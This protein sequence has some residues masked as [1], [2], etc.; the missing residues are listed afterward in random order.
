MTNVH[1]SWRF[2]ANREFN[3]PYQLSLVVI[4]TAVIKISICIFR[5]SNAT[6]N[7]SYTLLKFPLHSS[8]LCFISTI[9][10]DNKEL[11][12][13]NRISTE[14][15]RFLAYIRCRI[16]DCIY[17]RPRQTP[18]ETHIGSSSQRQ[19]QSR[20]EMRENIRSLCAYLQYLRVPKSDHGLCSRRQRSK[21]D[22]S[23]CQ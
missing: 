3:A 12:N 18:S 15:F 4:A 11:Q 7:V 13:D 16:R 14:F 20:F 9:Q 21:Q 19:T 2:Q 1:C 8:S 17:C 6:L 10:S 5:I 23:N 22:V